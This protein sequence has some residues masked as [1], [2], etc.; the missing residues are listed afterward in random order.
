YLYENYQYLTAFCRTHLPELNVIPLQS[1]YLVWLDCTALG[2][3]SFTIT[4]RLLEHVQ[5]WLNPGI[6][7][8]QS[9][10]Q[11]LRINIACPRELLEESLKRLEKEYKRIWNK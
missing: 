10:D 4:D 7:F 6:K 5:L 8:G 9:G 2:L 11:F 3:P 1:T